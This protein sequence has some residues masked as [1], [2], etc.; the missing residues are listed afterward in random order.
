MLY[1]NTEFLDPV[2]G[3]S[4]LY[5]AAFD[6]ERYVGVGTNILLNNLQI[7]IQELCN[8]KSSREHS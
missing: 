1:R 8:A 3:Y 5:Q 7:D 2:L 4:K 6:V